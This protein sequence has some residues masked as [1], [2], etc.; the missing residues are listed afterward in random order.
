MKRHGRADI[1]RFLRAVDAALEER[2]SILLI[3]GAA[4]MVHYGA[5]RPTHDIDTFQRV[6]PAL[7]RAVAVARART[8]L[9]IPVSFAAVADAPYDFE[10]RVERVSELQL[11]RLAI[12][13]PERHDLAL[14]KTIR[15]DEHDLE[16][17]AEL[18][19]K[20]PFD[21][22]VLRTRFR[23]EMS[24]VIAEPRCLELNFVS[25]VDRLFGAPTAKLEHD[26]FLRARRRSRDRGP[27]R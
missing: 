18:H 17:I 19:A 23:N 10:D 12:Y 5:E 26:E 4:A 14:M 15:G 9:D 24:H 27:E 1:E 2:A 6:S 16:L 7:E 3:G 20:Q 25:V 13:V 21:L 8:N 22:E 11:A